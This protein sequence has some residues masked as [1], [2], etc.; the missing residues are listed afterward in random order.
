MFIAVTPE[1]ELGARVRAA[2]EPVPTCR[3][4]E[5]SSHALLPVFAESW[6]AAGDRAGAPGCTQ[7]AGQAPPTASPALPSQGG[8]QNGSVS[9]ARAESAPLVSQVRSPPAFEQDK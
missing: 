4:D 1:L 6:D 5:G 9:K 3:E 7:G 8:N 2:A